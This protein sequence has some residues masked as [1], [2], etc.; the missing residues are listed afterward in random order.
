MTELL[1][2]VVSRLEG[3]DLVYVM[4]PVFQTWHGKHSQGQVSS[5]EA[6][7]TIVGRVVVCRNNVFQERKF[8]GKRWIKH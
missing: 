8:R 7:L 5:T 4:N 1:K 6:M 2:V 3:C